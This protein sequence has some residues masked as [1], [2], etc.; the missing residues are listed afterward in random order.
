[1]ILKFYQLQGKLVQLSYFQFM[2]QPHKTSGWLGIHVL[3]RAQKKQKSCGCAFWQNCMPVVQ[4]Q[5]QQLSLQATATVI[6]QTAIQEYTFKEEQCYNSSW[7]GTKM[8]NCGPASFFALSI[9]LLKRARCFFT[10]LK[11]IT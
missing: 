1:M 9:L 3:C 8:E 11:L 7:Y 4:H 2:Q 10:Y 5:R 6:S